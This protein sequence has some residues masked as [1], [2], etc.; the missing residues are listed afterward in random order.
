MK[1]YRRF[2]EDVH[3]ARENLML[4]SK[5]FGDVAKKRRNRKAKYRSETPRTAK[6]KDL[7]DRPNSWMGLESFDVFS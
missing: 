7:K 3:F 5:G 4:E 6:I 2:K 1:T